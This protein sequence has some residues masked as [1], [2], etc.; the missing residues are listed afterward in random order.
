MNFK[1]NCIWMSCRYAIGR[2]SA[3]S[4]Y[5]AKDVADHIDWIPSKNHEHLGRDILH[6]V[7]EKI[8]HYGN[9]HYTSVHNN[10]YDVFSIILQ[11]FLDNPQDNPIEYFVKHHWY[12][13]IDNKV[14]DNIRDRAIIVPDAELNCFYTFENIFMDYSNYI[15][16]IKLANILLN[17][18]RKV[19]TLVNCII[20]H[21]DCYEWYDCDYSTTDGDLYTVN[22]VKK[23]SD[24]E[25]GFPEW[26]F[27]PEYI[28]KIE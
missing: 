15:D 21:N 18:T 6:S 27:L 1:E 10:D 28:T 22:I 20:S 7:N 14:V 19:E 16:W 13:N 24:K 5:H 9:I 8:A 11:W 4:L 17:R 25:D 3:D 26:Y 23:Y 2:K 12:I